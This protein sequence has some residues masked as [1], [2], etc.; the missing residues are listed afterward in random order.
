MKLSRISALAFASAIALVAFLAPARA[1]AA[2]VF[3]YCNGN[4]GA[5]SCQDTTEKL[6]LDAMRICGLN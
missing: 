6:I 3:V 5:Y 2:C 1:E 4:Y